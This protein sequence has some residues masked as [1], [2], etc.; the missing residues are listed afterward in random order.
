MSEGSEREQPATEGPTSGQRLRRN[1]AV[2]GLS[3]ALLQALSFALMPLVARKLGAEPLGVWSTSLGLLSVLTTVAGLGLASSL[4]RVWLDRPALERSGLVAASQRRLGQAAVAVVGV[5]ALIAAAFAAA[6]RLAPWETTT[7]ALLL[8]TA[9]ALQFQVLPRAIWSTE[10]RAGRVVRLNLLT[11]GLF[12]VAAFAGIVGGG[13]GLTW[14]FGARFLASVA[15]ALSTLSFYRQ[16][17]GAPNQAAGDE[18]IRLGLPSV[19]H[20]LAHWALSIADRFVIGAMLG[21][22]AV[23]QY[24]VAYLCVDVFALGLHAMN[25]AIAPQVARWHSD[26][27]RRDYLTA[28]TSGYLR[29][30]FGALLLSMV[31]APHLVLLT[32]GDSFAPAARLVPVLL[33]AAGP[34]ALYF[35]EVG[36][37]FYQ[38]RVTGLPA[39][40]VTSALLSVAAVWLLIPI[41]GL[42]GA[43]LGTLIGYTLLWHFTRAIAVKAERV[44][45][46]RNSNLIA[47]GS[48]LL[49]AAVT[50]WM[51]LNGPLPVAA[52]LVLAPIGGWVCWSGLRILVARRG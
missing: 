34:W 29:T 48:W 41:M 2:Y 4:G 37:L 25:K 20:Q 26:P 40:T 42:L 19:P 8:A 1:L 32:F 24:A 51:A 12:V 16:H 14:L 13:A 30:A 33:L 18:A 45:A 6:G 43:A 31:A 9:L 39:A 46:D 7:V 49:C 11:N 52:C 28:L 50:P 10:E 22:A 23:G 15:A 27:T 35:P 47:A 17:R 21:F 5:A 44:T 36:A 38:R 3:D